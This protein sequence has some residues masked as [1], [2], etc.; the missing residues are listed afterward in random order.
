MAYRS[1]VKL[2][3][4]AKKIWNTVIKQLEESGELNQVDLPSI[5]AYCMEMDLYYKCMAKIADN[6]G[7]EKMVQGSQV[8][9]IVSPYY[10][11][12]K[13]AL[14]NAKSMADRFGLNSLSRKKM[15]ITED[16]E[17]NDPIADLLK[18]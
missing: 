7:V 12:A 6:A 13:T 1:P 4:D 8:M 3:K 9:D 11:N 5:A 14:S 18:G 16:K 17:E 15:K 10:K 2:N